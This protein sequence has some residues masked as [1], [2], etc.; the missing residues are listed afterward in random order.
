M[1]QAL[2]H[3]PGHRQI[4][5]GLTGSRQLFIVFAQPPG[6]QQPG[7]RAF[8]HPAARQDMEAARQRRGLLAGS[9]PDPADSRPPVLDDLQR[10]AHGGFNP[11]A[12]FATVGLE[13]LTKLEKVS[14]TDQRTSQREKG[15][16]NVCT[17]L[18]A[19]PQPAPLG[20]PRQGPFYNPARDTQATS[21]GCP[22]F[23]QHRGDPQRSQRPPMGL[24]IGAA[25][26]A[27]SARRF[28]RSSGRSRHPSTSPRVHFWT[29]PDW[30]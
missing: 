11:L 23:G 15:F 12:R 8:H 25:P 19:Y 1:G 24:R 17:P 4:D 9:H 30:L 29:F 3:Q 28:V 27:L 2:D 14:P 7:E 13:P 22:A 6:H 16:M 26:G 21:V 5:E 20:Q 18:I 10:A